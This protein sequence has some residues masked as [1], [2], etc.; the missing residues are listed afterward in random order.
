MIISIVAACIMLAGVGQHTVYAAALSQQGSKT[1]VTANGNDSA[2]MPIN[3]ASDLSD[4]D[5][6]GQT[7]DQNGDGQAGGSLDQNGDVQ[8]DGS[9]DQ[10][11]EAQ[12]DGSSDQ[13]GDGQAGDSSD[14]NGDIQPDGSSDQNGDGQLG[15]SSDQNGDG[16]ARS[17]EHTSEL[18][19]H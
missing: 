13:N 14:Q 8:P 9:S 6:G 15:D 18:Q 16:Q 7:P 4:P 11:G 17:E 1:A 10:N 3:K 19:S 2:D 12:P 5:G